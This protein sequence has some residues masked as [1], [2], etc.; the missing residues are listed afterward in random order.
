LSSDQ[1]TTSDADVR[2]DTNTTIESTP[3]E[4][5]ELPAPRYESWSW[6][7]T[8]FEV[9]EGE[10]DMED[11]WFRGY[12]ETAARYYAVAKQTA[13]AD[14]GI[15]SRGTVQQGGTGRILYPYP[16]SPGAELVGPNVSATRQ[17]IVGAN[18]EAAGLSASPAVTV[19]PSFSRTTDLDIVAGD[20]V[21]RRLN[22]D[23]EW[24][25][26]TLDVRDGMLDM[27]NAWFRSRLRTESRTYERSTVSTQVP[28]GVIPRGYVK[29]GEQARLV[30][31]IPADAPIDSWGL[32]DS[33]Q[34][35]TIVSESVQ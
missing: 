8:E 35:V 12:F 27:A 9:L 23:T 7:V 21:G 31:Q 13:E 15:E 25:V 17:R 1:P 22:D 29:S 33:Q 30:Y 10:L 4:T 24:A 2:L 28:Y 6:I 3:A 11:V 5:A 19:A 32:S 18:I 34:D 16:P 14:G 26:V 20:D